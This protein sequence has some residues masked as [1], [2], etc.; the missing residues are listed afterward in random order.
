MD[1]VT[2]TYSSKVMSVNFMSL[3]DTKS[4]K[5]D[6]DKD[7][8][9]TEDGKHFTWISSIGIYPGYD[10]KL[11]G[12][13]SSRRNIENGTFKPL[14]NQGYNLIHNYGRRYTMCYVI[15]A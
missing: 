9:I 2:L 7:E 13:C 15:A 4:R 11:A 3:D 10:V 8:S 5:N 12:S 14:K 1:D 6:S